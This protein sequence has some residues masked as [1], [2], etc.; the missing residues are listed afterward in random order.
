LKSVFPQ[1]VIVRIPNWIG[2]AVVS[3]SSIQGIQSRYPSLQISVMGPKAITSLLSEFSD[4]VS[5]HP[6]NPS[7]QPP[8]DLGFCFPLSFR[9]AYELWRVPS[10]KRIGYAHEGRSFFLSHRLSYSSWETRHL[11]QVTYYQEMIQS[12]FHDLTFAPPKLSV[13]EPRR[14]EAMVQNL[15]HLESDDVLLAVNPGAFFGSAKTWP[16]S[17][18]ISLLSKLLLD[19]PKIRIILFSGEKDREKADVLERSLLKEKV[20][21]LQGKTSLS[22]S[23]AILSG[24]DYLLTND[25]GMM[26]MGAAL[27]IPGAVFFGPTDPVAT[28]PLGGKIRVLRHHV[29]CAPCLLREC[30]IDHRCMTGLTWEAVHGPIVEDLRKILVHKESKISKNKISAG[31]EMER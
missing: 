20:V 14:R 26:H 21:P 29:T 16:S 22:D 23:L 17:S 5:Y 30:P 7:E 24:C 4:V 9:S 12:V 15:R 6:E 27:G 13:P 28:G 18:F 8:F 10:K 19:Y 2:D 1:R 31:E 3:L 25:S 11:H